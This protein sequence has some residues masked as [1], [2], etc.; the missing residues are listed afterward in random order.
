MLKLMAGVA[1][2]LYDRLYVVAVKMLSKGFAPANIF[3]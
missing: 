2:P 1:A 3:I